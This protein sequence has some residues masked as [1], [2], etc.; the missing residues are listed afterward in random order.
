MHINLFIGHAYTF[1]MLSLPYLNDERTCPKNTP[2]SELKWSVSM[3]TD[4]HCRNLQ[5][6]HFLLWYAHLY[7]SH[8]GKYAIPTR[9]MYRWL[10]CDGYFLFPKLIILHDHAHSGGTHF[11]DSLSLPNVQFCKT[12]VLLWAMMK[13]VFMSHL[14]SYQVMNFPTTIAH[15]S[16]HDP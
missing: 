2:W 7:C 6:L 16:W 10:Q 5:C 15:E 11:H 1:F 3:I 13:W 4:F 9:F 14:T 8:Y 12:L